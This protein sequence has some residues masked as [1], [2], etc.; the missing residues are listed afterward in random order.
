M[1]LINCFELN[2]SKWFRMIL[3]MVN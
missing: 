1:N 3:I 2:W